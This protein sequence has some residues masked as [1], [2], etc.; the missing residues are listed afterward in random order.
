MLASQADTEAWVQPKLN[1]QEKKTGQNI[2]GE[3]QRAKRKMEI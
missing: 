2:S 1:W 3:K